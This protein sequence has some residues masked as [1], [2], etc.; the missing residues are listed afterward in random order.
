MSQKNL[1][2]QLLEYLD[3]LPLGSLRILGRMKGV[4]HPSARKKDD[5]MNALID[6][7]TE[8]TKPVTIETGKSKKGAH[9][10]QDFIDP[11]V[12]EM[13]EKMLSR[14]RD[15]AVAEATKFTVATS[16]PCHN[17]YDDRIYTGVLDITSNGYGFVRVKNCQPTPNG[18]VFIPSDKIQ[19]YKLR[20]GDTIACHARASVKNDSAAFTELLSVNGMPIGSYENRP[21][22]DA[23]TAYFPKEKF[24]LSDR[25]E[26]IS[27]RV[28]DLFSPVGKGQRG[29]I[30]APPKAGKTSLLKDIARSLAKTEN[31]AL[32]VLLIDERPEEVTDFRMTV[33]GAEI[34]S[35]TFDEGAWHHIRAADLVLAHAKRLAEAGK[36]VVILLDSLT[37]LTRAHNIVAESSGKTL[38]GGLDPNALG[39]PKRFFG[40]ARNLEGKGSLTILAT[41]LVDT[42]S[43][44]DDVVYEEFK[45]TGNADIV[46]SRDLSERR[47]FPAFD[48]RR[49]GTRKDELLLSEEELSG[50]RRLQSR[51]LADNT[52]GVLDM[53]TKTDNNEEFLARL[54]SWLKV[55]KH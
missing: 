49:S 42:G 17:A 51:G 46:L 10:K 53:M 8:K 34:I 22:F 48:L 11:A 37:K 25:G 16:E 19:E 18:D 36:D 31:V 50:V 28:L 54:D 29:L 24:R 20:V 6:V 23:L 43:R 9:P 26:E 39:G 47:V 12:L 41:V 4:D 45:G 14:A 40:A 52:E 15:A 55:Y 30:I 44:L 13:I 7:L 38:S 32:I 27:L 5:L 33:E 21:Y 2:E 1:E 3:S 35:S